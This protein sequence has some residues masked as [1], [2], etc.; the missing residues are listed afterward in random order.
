MLVQHERG[1][2]T[3]IIINAAACII[4]SCVILLGVPDLFAGYAVRGLIAMFCVYIISRYIS[5]SLNLLSE[6]KILASA[7][8]YRVVGLLIA[9]LSLFAAFETI[10]IGKLSGMV[11]VPFVVIVGEL[12][13]C[14]KIALHRRKTRR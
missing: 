6:N 12:G 8:S 2:R 5:R 13:E 10:F 7:A 9:C 11:Y 1:I 3:I 4:A 14:R